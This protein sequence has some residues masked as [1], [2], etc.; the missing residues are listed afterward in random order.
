MRS[1]GPALL[2]AIGFGLMFFCMYTEGEPAAIPLL[3]IVVSGVWY[4]AVRIRRRQ[5]AH[6]ADR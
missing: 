1:I 3:L 6:A 2:A 5:H 4:A